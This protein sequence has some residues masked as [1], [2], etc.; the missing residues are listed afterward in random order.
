MLGL[1]HAMS[2]TLMIR[3]RCGRALLHRTPLL[4]SNQENVRHDQDRSAA[5]SRGM[6]DAQR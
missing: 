4:E 1:V 6:E 5:Q 2:D 3:V